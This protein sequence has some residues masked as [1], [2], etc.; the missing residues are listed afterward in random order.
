[1]NGVMMGSQ[2]PE[3]S[4]RLSPFRVPGT[5]KARD[6]VVAGLEGPERRWMPVA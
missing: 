2:I 5:Q 3:I 6:R 1:M 4:V